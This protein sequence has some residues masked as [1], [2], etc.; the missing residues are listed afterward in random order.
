MKTRN[1]ASHQS[2]YS[3][4]LKAWAAATTGSFAASRRLDAPTHSAQHQLPLFPEHAFPNRFIA[5]RGAELLTTFSDE[6]GWVHEIDESR[7]DLHLVKTRD[8][9]KARRQ[10]AA[11]RSENRMR[12][13]DLEKCARTIHAEMLRGGQQ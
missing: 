7:P 10:L 5:D 8:P 9:G 3:N 6:S 4:P 13:R 1:G 11:I 12:N 2:I